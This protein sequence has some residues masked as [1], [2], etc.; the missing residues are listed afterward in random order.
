MSRV[1]A[2]VLLLAALVAW[3]PEALASAG[4]SPWINVTANQI[5]GVHRVVHRCRTLAANKRIRVFR[6]AD[7]HGYDIVFGE[8]RPTRRLMELE[9]EP[10][11][12]TATR[13][14]GEVLAYA[15]SDRREASDS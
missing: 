9:F 13:L 15:V 11:R 1:V 4:A 14:A 8:W 6:A 5:C 10:P 7:R 3:A 12:I 2:G